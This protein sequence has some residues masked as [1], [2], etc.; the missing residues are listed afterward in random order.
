MF[1]KLIID[2][3]DLHNQ[4]IMNLFLDYKA[5]Y[6]YQN[7]GDCNI[8]YW[9]SMDYYKLAYCLGKDLARTN[10]KLSQAAKDT[11]NKFRND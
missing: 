5:L 2:T 7:K 4:L 11:I 9:T 1:F 10:V 3:L 6:E 8:P